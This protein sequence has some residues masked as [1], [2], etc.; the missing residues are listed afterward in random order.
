MD[1]DDE[2][3]ALS[4]ALAAE[5][6]DALKELLSHGIDPNTRIDDDGQTLLMYAAMSGNSDL[7]SV[8]LKFGSDV[9]AT[10]QGGQTAL[11]IATFMG[12]VSFAKELLAAGANV[13]AI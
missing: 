2:R 6:A 7:A 13:D 9:N 10:S 8:L 5:S 1:F 11:H 3:I 12:R 4:V